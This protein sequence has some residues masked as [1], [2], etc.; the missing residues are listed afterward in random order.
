MEGVESNPFF[1]NVHIC[2]VLTILVGQCLG[3]FSP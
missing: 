3:V 1:L 2:S